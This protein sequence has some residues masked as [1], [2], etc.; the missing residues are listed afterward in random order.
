MRIHYR[1]RIFQTFLLF[2]ATALLSMNISAQQE[3]SV[4]GVTTK[5]EPPKTG[6]RVLKVLGDPAEEAGMQSMDVISRYGNYQIVDASSYF[7]A[8]EAYEKFPQSKVEVIYWHNRERVAT[9][10]KPGRLNIEFNEYGAVAYH[11]GALIKNLDSMIA[12]PPYWV[13]QQTGKGPTEMR[14][15]LIPEINVAI[16][17][18]ELDGSLT[19]AQI[20]VARI[21]AIPDDRAGCRSGKAISTD[22]GTDRKTAEQFHRVPGV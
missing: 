10:V 13:D 5:E 1:T 17:K 12:L 21:N 2:A 22:N 11:L 7:A 14:D 9:W 16:D 20:L 4:A 3:R 18:A 15:K 8:R 6:L 19:P